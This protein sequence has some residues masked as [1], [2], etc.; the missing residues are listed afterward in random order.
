MAKIL[1]EQTHCSVTKIYITSTCDRTGK[2]SMRAHRHLAQPAVHSHR[3]EWRITGAAILCLLLAGCSQPAADPTPTPP[4]P[5]VTVSHPLQR[6]VV[7]W[8]EYTG[9]LE[10][11]ETVEIRARVNGYLQKVL[12]K[13]GAKVRKGDLLFVIDPRPYQAKL[14][15]AEAEVQRLKARLELARNDL[16]R[17]DRLLRSRVI[18]EEEHDVR[19]KGLREAEATLKA[20]QAAVETTRLN[21]EFTHIRA[22]ISGRISRKYL[23][24]GNLVNGDSGQ[25]TLLAT[26]VSIG[27]IY[28]YFDVDERSVL[29]YQRLTHE[30]KLESARDTKVPAELALADET[31]FPHKGYV[32]YVEPR[33]DPNTGT[34]CLRGVFANT[35]DQLSPGLFARVRVPGSG[36]FKA[37]LVSDH[38]IAMNQGQKYVLV[39]NGENTVEY[40][41]VKPGP[42][43]E[44]LRVID[45]GLRPEDRVIVE[46]IQRV[47]PGTWVRRE[48][49]AML[50]PGITPRAVMAIA[51]TQPASRPKA[52]PQAVKR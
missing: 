3:S 47:R 19:S 30:G 29:R 31:G 40:R 21:V 49:T 39:V 20:A 36:K 51:S 45:E 16:V 35:E 13:D 8:D 15:R 17:A 44:G 38:V 9:R 4:P 42:L 33:L 12:F 46:G 14:D 5:A 1:V 7:E 22:P 34:V 23:N 28:V 32:D 10:A 25:A 2:T 26:L 43:I 27:P 52:I 18:S 50:G 48:H 37:L 41:P 6:E 11:V 24:E